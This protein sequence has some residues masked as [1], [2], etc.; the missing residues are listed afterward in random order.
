MSDI[1]QI[2]LEKLKEYDPAVVELA[3]KALDYAEQNMPEPTIAEQ[4]ENVVRQIV[5]KKESEQ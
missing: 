3:V 4:L 1:N 2:I 5:K